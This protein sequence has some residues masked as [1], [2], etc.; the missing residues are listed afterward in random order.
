MP[1][2]FST[3]QA[4]AAV[5][6]ASQK[7]MRDQSVS[8]RFHFQNPVSKVIVVRN[9]G[10]AQGARRSVFSDIQP[11][12]WLTSSGDW[13]AYGTCLPQPRSQVLSPTRLLSLAP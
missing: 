7:Y 11:R 2:D 10:K 5:L 13:I 4:V 8:A 6:A 1:G 9:G 12:E 3:V